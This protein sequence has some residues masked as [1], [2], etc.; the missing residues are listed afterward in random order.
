MTRPIILAALLAA[1][2]AQAVT[3]APPISPAKAQ[4]AAPGAPS[5]TPK[6]FPGVSDQGNATLA[7]LQTTPDPQLQAL[8]RQAKAAHDQLVS[9]AMAPVIDMDKVA[10]ALKAQD[11]ALD[12]V[13]AHNTDRIIAA[14]R[15]LS[16][17]DRGTFLRT[18][19]LAQSQRPVPPPAPAKP[20]P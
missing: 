2:G 20:Q 10:A 15:L 17:D 19:V 5:N 12:A 6:R 1:G 3:V 7:K 18:L 16:D 13:R 11:E 14:A 4:P 9:A 8:G